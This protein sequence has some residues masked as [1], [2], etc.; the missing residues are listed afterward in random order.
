[1]SAMRR[2]PDKAAPGQRDLPF[3]QPAALD[4]SLL[5]IG[6]RAVPVR[7]AKHRCARRYI[8][9]MEEDGRIRLT[10]PRGGSREEALRFAR[11]HGEW[12][13]RQRL[14][15][16][17]EETRRRLWSEGTLVHFRGDLVALKVHQAAKGWIV[18]LG[19]QEIGVPAAQNLRPHVERHLRLL[20]ASELP[21]RLGELSNVIGVEVGRVSIRSQKSR[22]GSCSTTGTITLNWRLVQMPPPVSDYVMLH[23]LVHRLVP[24]HSR[25]FW[26]LVEK[27]CPHHREA[28]DWLNRHGNE[29]G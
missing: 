2:R 13:L 7:F 12:I 8:V 25:R 26:R 9:R 21:R 4:E 18:T 28:R 23:E 19:D 5:V 16:L 24:S 22:W 6:S 20:A 15:L 11:G 17:K 14:A 10:V 1:M 3:G 27:A 29:L